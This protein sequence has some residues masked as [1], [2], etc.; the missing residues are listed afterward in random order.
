MLTKSAVRKGVR[1]F[2]IFR[3]GKYQWEFGMVLGMISLRCLET[4]KKIGEIS[5]EVKSGAGNLGH[6]DQVL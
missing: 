6:S 4:A 2:F 3:G 5:L 1:W